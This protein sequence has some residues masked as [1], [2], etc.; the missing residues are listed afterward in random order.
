MSWG[1]KLTGSIDYKFLENS[2]TEVQMNLIGE[3]AVSIIQEET[4][5]RSIDQYGR[6]FKPYSKAYAEYRDE[7]LGRGKGRKVDLSFTRQMLKALGV[8]ENRTTDRQV[9]IGFPTDAAPA[10]GGLRPSQKM[11]RTNKTRPWFGFG[12]RGSARRRRIEQ[13]ASEIFIEALTRRF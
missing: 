2:L 11:R 8:I 5:E 4:E 7:E 1:M 10:R 12:P 3:A 9:T 6:P 13:M